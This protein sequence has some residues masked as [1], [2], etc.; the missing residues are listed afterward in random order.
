M[1]NRTEKI[2]ALKALADFNGRLIQNMRILIKELRGERLED[3]DKLQT[4][5]INAINWE[6]SVMCATM[7]LLNEETETIKKDSFND[8]I[9]ALAGALQEKEDNRIAEA[10]ENLIIE[11]QVLGEATR[12]VIK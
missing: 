7:D 10:L 6:I 1:E 4:D 5:V 3:T 9:Q 8:K 2:E 12:K 11:F